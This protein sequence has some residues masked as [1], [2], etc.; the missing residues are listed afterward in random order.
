METVLIVVVGWVLLNVAFFAAVELH[1]VVGV[2][3]RRSRP[4]LVVLQGGRARHDEPAGG[5]AWPAAPTG[6]R[7]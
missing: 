6:A 2:R 4:A 1:A 7:S 5:A 3:S